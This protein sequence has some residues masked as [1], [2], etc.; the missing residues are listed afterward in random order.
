VVVATA[1]LFAALA[2]CGESEPEPFA[3]YARTPIP[4]TGS[5]SLP[6]V[7]A[8]G[9]ETPFT[10]V[11]GEGKL[12]LVYF[13]YTSCPDVCPTTLSDIRRAL[14]NMGGDRAD[15]V[16]LAMVTIDVDVDSPEVLTNYVRSFV[17][18]AVAVRSTDDSQLRAAAGVFGADY[19]KDTIDGKEEVYHTGS[20]YAVDDQGDMLLTWPFGTPSTDIE[21]DLVRLLDGERA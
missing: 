1:L 7:D 12:L 20:L 8:D 11:A 15:R 17:P 5:V 21:S 16:D 13:G 3:G 2:G 9:S 10:F 6:S 14:D 18:S 4:N 19:G